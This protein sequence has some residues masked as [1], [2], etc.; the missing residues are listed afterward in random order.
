MIL[1]EVIKIEKSSWEKY[2]SIWRST[3]SS[4]MKDEEVSFSIHP[5]LNDTLSLSKS[6]MGIIN[7]RS[8]KYIYLSENISE[9]T[10]WPKHDYLEYGA[11]FV[12]SR[13]PRDDQMGLV[14]FSRIIN[15]YFDS[16]S[17]EEKEKY[18]SFYDYPIIKPDGKLARILQHDR[19]LTYDEKGRVNI[20]LF[21]CFDI[22][23]DKKDG[24]QHLRITN[25]SEGFIYE[26]SAKNKELKQLDEPSKRELEVALLINKG[27]SRKQV[28]ECLGLSFHTV[29]THCKNI[30]EKL[31]VT[32]STEMVSL[33]ASL[34]FF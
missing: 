10:H 6:A 34:G 26:F 5:L 13:I 23:D 16:L 29:T 18:R 28:A 15:S 21:T 2:K 30:A 11:E 24:S 27:L 33:L 14:E 8:M 7:T 12:F 4:M 22:S 17:T 3:D 9:M 19:V 31:N 25:G 20:V 1:D 32:Y